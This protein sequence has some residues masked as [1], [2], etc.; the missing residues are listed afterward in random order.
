MKRTAIVRT[1][2]LAVGAAACVGAGMLAQGKINPTDPQ[3]SC[4]M[5]PGTYIPVSE[6]EAYTKKAI[7]EKLTDQQVRDIDI[8][9]AH[10]AIGMVYR[11]K[12]P[13]SSTGSG[14]RRRIGRCRSSTGRD[15]TAPTSATGSRTRS[16]PATSW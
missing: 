12:G 3:P 5:C 6:L 2:L 9:K 4:E 1:C 16:R 14:V 15:T 7:A 8:G 11:G 10:V 13:T